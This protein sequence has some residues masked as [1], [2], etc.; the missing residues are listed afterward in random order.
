MIVPYRLSTSF[1][2]RNLYDGNRTTA[3][4]VIKTQSRF[5]RFFVI[6]YPPGGV[7]RQRSR[8]SKTRKMDRDR[9]VKFR[10]M[11]LAWVKKQEK[12]KVDSGSGSS[13]GV[14]YNPDYQWDSDDRPTGVPWAVKKVKLPEFSDDLRLRLAQLSMVGVAQHWF[15]IISQVR[16]SLSWVDFQSELLQ[17]FSGLEI[18]NP[19]EQLSAIEQSDSIHDYIDDFEYLLSLVP[20]LPESQTLGYFI[21]GLKDDVK[22]LVRLHWPLSR[23]DAM[24]LAKDV[25]GMLQPKSPAGNLAIS[26]FR[27]VHPPSQYTDCHLE[28]F[29]N[30]GLVEPKSIFGPKGVE[31]SSTSR[32]DVSRLSWH[33]KNLNSSQNDGAPGF[34]KERGSVLC[35][36]PNGKIDARRVCFRC[37][38]QYGP[39]HKCPEGKLRVLLLGED[40]DELQEGDNLQL[41]HVELSDD[42]LG[43]AKISGTCLALASDG[44]VSNGGGAKTLKFEGM[45]HS[46]PLSLMVDSGAIHN[47]ISRRLV[48]AMGLS[49]SVFTSIH[50]T[51]GDG[52]STGNLGLIL[53]M[54]WLSSLGEVLHD[55]NHSWTQFT[56]KGRVVRLQGLPSA[57]VPPAALQQW[58]GEL[59]GGDSPSAPCGC[60]NAALSVSQQQVLNGLLQTM[61]FV[62]D[63]PT[64][65]PPIRSHDHA[66]Q[67]KTDNTGH[68]M[69]GLKASMAFQFQQCEMSYCAHE[70]KLALIPIPILIGVVVAGILRNRAL[71]LSPYLMILSSISYSLNVVII[72][73]QTHCFGS[74]MLKMCF[75]KAETEQKNLSH[76]SYGKSVK[77]GHLLLIGGITRH[78]H[79]LAWDS[80][81]VSRCPKVPLEG[82]GSISSIGSTSTNKKTKGP[83]DSIFKPSVPSGKKWG[84]LV[85][86][87]EYRQVQKKLRLDAIQK[88]CR[89]MYDAGLPFNSV[90]YDSLG[91]AFE[92]IA[93]HG[94]G[95]KPPQLS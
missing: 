94:C 49:V 87:V 5:R 12:Q 72:E 19:Y 53:G 62:F 32:S 83:L 44:V 67:L 60:L 89:W 17:C 63:A 56:H 93:R 7:P 38:Q 88:F 84:N 86:S 77:M 82:K 4:I 69:D 64:G 75:G 16:D 61:S 59:D 52:Y 85:G 15:T 73:D 25:E 54:A 55:W 11:V 76:K 91:P 8:R 95:I 41:E 3:T 45:L 1:L 6:H 51:L 18:Q 14:F 39:A 10:Q 92:A 35:L 31:R 46:I 27:Y 71:K 40:E 13:G 80:A 48:G 57:Q 33:T 2:F 66:I 43:E 58:L 20:R 36:V 78:K 70:R 22:Q 21:A 68:P 42:T 9:G 81:N 34:T 23:L 30:L 79:H 24:Y 65:L 28:G 47:F 74:V 29:S 26:R 50:I 90:M 37:G